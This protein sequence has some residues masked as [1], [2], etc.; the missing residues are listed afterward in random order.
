M[1]NRYKGNQMTECQISH[2]P[3]NILRNCLAQLIGSN[4]VWH[5]YQHCAGVRD[6]LLTRFFIMVQ[7]AVLGNVFNSIMSKQALTV[8]KIKL[9]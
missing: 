4:S 3:I 6:Q 1:K 8:A 5:L 9:S 7:R 2:S